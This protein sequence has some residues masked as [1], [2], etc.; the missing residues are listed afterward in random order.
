MAEKKS[1]VKAH[2]GFMH[3]PK[4]RGPRRPVGDPA[5]K[6]PIGRPQRPYIPRLPRGP[7]RPNFSNQQLQQMSDAQLR[8]YFNAQRRRNIAHQLRPQNRIRFFDRLNQANLSPAERKREI[9]RYNT[10]ISNLKKGLD[11]SGKPI[12]KG[13]DMLKG[14]RKA[15]E[16]DRKR[17]QQMQQQKQKM[18]TKKPLTDIKDMSQNLLTNRN[19]LYKAAMDV[20]RQNAAAAQQALENTNR[21]RP[22]T[23]EPLAQKARARIPNR[24]RRMV[25][26]GGTVRKKK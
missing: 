7:R 5:P 1:K 25:S 13:K 24:R 14:F 16:Q 10:F 26:K 8:R 15:M 4:R 11:Y 9:A 17:F 12:P 6:R 18:P 19:R 20:R 2:R 23:A 22:K 3:V 21:R